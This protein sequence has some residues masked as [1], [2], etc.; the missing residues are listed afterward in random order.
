VTRNARG[1]QLTRFGQ[2]VYARARLILAEMQHAR[3]DVIQLSGGKEGALACALTPLMSLGFLPAA[4]DAFR[5]RM[6][7]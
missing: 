7:T 3:D 6:P 1:A 2:A 4:L 5:Q